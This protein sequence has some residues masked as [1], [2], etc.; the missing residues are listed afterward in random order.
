M[1]SAD[2]GT[3]ARGRKPSST[4]LV[5]GIWKQSLLHSWRY[6]AHHS[7]LREGLLPDYQQSIVALFIIL[8]NC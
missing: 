2:V 3:T 7:Y 6:D 4:V 1:S 5:I 8:I